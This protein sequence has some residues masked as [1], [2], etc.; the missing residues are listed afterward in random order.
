MPIIRLI[1]AGV[2]VV[3][4]LLFALVVAVVGVVLFCIQRLLGRRGG[5]AS[6]KI[7]FQRGPGTSKNPPP[8]RMARD[9]A[10]DIDATE[11]KADNAP[12]PR[13]EG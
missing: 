5:T 13:L 7:N 8:T 6:F 12:K 10:I 11:I 3:F 9:G 1:I 4:G 2:V